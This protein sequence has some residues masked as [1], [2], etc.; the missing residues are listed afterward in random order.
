MPLGTVRM[1]GT[2]ETS[3]EVDY[4]KLG[5]KAGQSL[6][7]SGA[8][9][10]GG[11]RWGESWT[12]CGRSAGM[13]SLPEQKAPRKRSATKSSATKNCRLWA[14][15]PAAWLRP[16]PRFRPLRAP[17]PRALWGRHR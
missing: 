15:R 4:A 11:H 2:G 1:L 16:L 13:V 5:L 10:N 7:M 9:V 14:P 3:V 17:A 8:W 6:C 12:G